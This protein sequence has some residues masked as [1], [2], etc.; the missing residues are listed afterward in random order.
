[1]R[2]KIQQ[3]PLYLFLFPVFFVL[4]GFTQNFYFVSIKSAFIL[5]VTYIISSLIIAGL[6]YFFYKSFTKAAVMAIF[7]MSFHFFFG[8]VYDL[9][10]RYLQ[11]TFFIKYSFLISGFIILGIIL[12]FIIRK[13]KTLFT[14]SSYLNI[15]F[16]LLILIDTG[17]LTIQ[18][19]N[20]KQTY[21][22]VG[23]RYTV[24]DSCTKPDVYIILLDE[25]AGAEELKDLFNYNNQPFFDSLSLRG[26]RTIINSQSNYNYTPCSVASIL[27]ME[28]LDTQK[29]NN[30]PKRFKYVV[31]NINNNKLI[32]FF[33]ANGYIFFNHSVFKV[34]GQAAPIGGSFVP[35][36]AKLINENTF[37]SRLEK[38][39]LVNI[40][41][42]FNLKWYFK[43]AMYTTFNDNNTLY[44][45]TMKTPEINLTHP[46]IIYT[47]LMMPHFPYYYNE[48][49]DLLSFNSLKTSVLADT[50]A[51]LSYLNYTNKKIAAL[52]D[53][54][55]SNSSTPPIIALLSDHGYRYYKNSIGAKY[56]FSNL[57]SIHL[58]DRNYS[59]YRD[60]MSCVNFFRVLLN[61]QFKQKLPLL[62]DKTFSIDF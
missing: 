53:H 50:A 61:S 2:K 51:Y 3:S 10:I 6:F 45:L 47:H 35:A 28:Y 42:K 5:T 32:S 31:K 9:L 20:K 18:I 4:H 43:K 8:P 57:L 1:M 11:H 26:F 24:C 17:S 7:I 39:V 49:G 58:P 15:L 38:D 44:D 37:L 27:N 19:L 54:I 46:K 40:A 21:K 33:L 52:V 13:R 62:E 60:S 55:L 14:L 41:Y 12:F 23:P 25:Y 48:R 34:A 30:T 16:V 29:I 36:N 22:H 56:G 59:L